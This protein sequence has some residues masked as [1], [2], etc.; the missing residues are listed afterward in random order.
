MNEFKTPAH[1][2]AVPIEDDATIAKAVLALGHNLGLRVV[3][4]GVESVEQMHFLRQIHCE[5]AQGYYFSRPVA[6]DTFPPL[7]A[8][9][10]TR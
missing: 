1:Q 2:P 8:A 7:L 6:R 4:E 9:D 10:W 3:A 5:E